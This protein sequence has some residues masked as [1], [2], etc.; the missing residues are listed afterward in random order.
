MRAFLRGS[1]E[2]PSLFVQQLH[3]PSPKTVESYRSML[4]GFWRFTM[5]EASRKPL[6]VEVMRRWLVHR[7]ASR[8]D[9]YVYSCARL[10][11]R[12][13]D[14]KVATGACSA[15]SFALLK[16]QYGLKNT[17][18]IVRALLSPNPKQA[19]ERLRPLPRF[20]SFLGATMRFGL[21]GSFRAAP[22]FL[23]SRLTS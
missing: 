6:P 1:G 22:I 15:N 12:F 18:P 23:G 5:K 20:G 19:L 7:S 14:W 21:I 16:K 2:V 3:L 11:D 17:R 9:C 8:R 4:N 10:V 13:L